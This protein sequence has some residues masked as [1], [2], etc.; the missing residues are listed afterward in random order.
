MKPTAL[1]TGITG[2]IGSNLVRRLVKE[3]WKV[4]AIVRMNSDLSDLADIKES[5]HI[6][7]YDG[8]VEG[9]LGIFKTSKPHIVFHLASLFL[10]E[11]QPNQ[12]SALIQSNVLFS[13]QLVEGM[14][15]TGCKRLINAGTSWQH[16]HT[17]EYLPVNLYAATK[18][19]FEDILAY[20]QDAQGLSCITLKLFD[21]YGPS[22]K[23][24]KLINLIIEAATSNAVL[25]M[26][27][28]EQV[29]DI[30]H[31]DDV[32]DSFIEGANFLIN[33]SEKVVRTF[34]ISGERLT[35][36]ELVGEVEAST[37]KQINAT[38]GA[39]PYRNREVMKLPEVAGLTPPWEK[40]MKKSKLRDELFKLLKEI[41]H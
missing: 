4:H 3:S 35:V 17:S 34:F 10:A 1:V 2:F 40:G 37:G 19:A 7:R 39:R 13:A 41:K 18:Q 32:V 25:G 12:V 33:A 15:Q 6:H 21:T 14:V 8:T 22:D 36:K 26:S 30:S 38:F 11:H 28:G 24:K 5:C 29:I 23:R 9:M 16:Y 20:Y 27:P 31:I